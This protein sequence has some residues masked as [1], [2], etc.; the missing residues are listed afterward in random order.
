MKLKNKPYGVCALPY[1]EVI[2]VTVRDEDQLAV[3]GFQRSKLVYNDKIIGPQVPTYCRGFSV[4][5]GIFND[6]LLVVSGGKWAGNEGVATYHVFASVQK[7]GL[8]GQISLTPIDSAD[9]S[10]GSGTFFPRNVVLSTDCNNIFITDSRIGVV[11]TDIKGNRIGTITDPILK[12]AR[13]LCIDEIGNLYVGGM[14]SANVVK[15]SPDGQLIGEVL[16]GSHGLKCP[17]SL[18]YDSS[19]RSLLIGCRETTPFRIV[20]L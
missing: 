1:S 6:T 10:T 15:F 13:G 16:N 19:T 9:L 7:K 14:D 18:C 11:V 3:M 4:R 8:P 20:K 5:K 2:A 12:G 17:I